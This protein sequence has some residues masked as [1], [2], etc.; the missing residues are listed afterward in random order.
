MLS[1]SSDLV[2]DGPGYSCRGETSGCDEAPELDPVYGKAWSKEKM[3][4]GASKKGVIQE[5]LRPWIQ[6]W[7]FDFPEGTRDWLDPGKRFALLKCIRYIQKM[8]HIMYSRYFL[9]HFNSKRG[10]AIKYKS[11]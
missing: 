7:S 9:L 11:K 3:S 2:K 4:M 10:Q 8:A 6:Y 1:F 5:G